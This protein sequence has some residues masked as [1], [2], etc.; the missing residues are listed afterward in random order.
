MRVDFIE[1]AA[2]TNLYN[3]AF[4]P[5]AVIGKRLHRR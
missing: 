1:T 4:D 5:A 3:P 2:E